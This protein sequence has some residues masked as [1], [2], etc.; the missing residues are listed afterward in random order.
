MAVAWATGSPVAAVALR[1][2]DRVALIDL[3]THAVVDAFPVGD[4]PA[5]VVM[6]PDGA[7]LYVALATSARVI[8]G[9]S[10]R[11]WML[12][13][14]FSAIGKSPGFQPSRR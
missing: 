7:A 14:I 12:R 13:Q 11:V 1:G 6:S 5:N 8:A 3:G 4:E 10:G 2:E 9:K